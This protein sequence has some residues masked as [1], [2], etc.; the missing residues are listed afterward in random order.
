M[1]VTNDPEVLGKRG[2]NRA[3]LV[4]NL[5]V[6]KRGRGRTLVGLEAVHRVSRKAF[7]DSM[8]YHLQRCVRFE[9]GQG[10]SLASGGKHRRSLLAIGSRG[11]RLEERI[12][13]FLSRLE[14][15]DKLID[16]FAISFL[17][18][19]I[20]EVVELLDLEESTRRIE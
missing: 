8:G 3:N 20:F 1:I 17:I 5:L 10:E 4:G 11:E 2:G 15:F 6:S 13:G 7:G 14:D 9:R 18:F 16:N 19:A 12:Q